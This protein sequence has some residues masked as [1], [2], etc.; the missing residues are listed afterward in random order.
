MK[1]LASSVDLMNKLSTSTKNAQNVA[2]L[3]R[4]VKYCEAE[5][6]DLRLPFVAYCLSV[7]KVALAEE[8]GCEEPSGLLDDKVG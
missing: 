2:A 6:S 8:T 5:A 3:A 4:M 1:H 7:A